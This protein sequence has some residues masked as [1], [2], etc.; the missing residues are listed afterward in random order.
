MTHSPLECAE[1]LEAKLETRGYKLSPF[2]KWAI[3][4]MSEFRHEFREYCA[5]EEIYT[6]KVDLALF[7]PME[8]I[9]HVRAWMKRIFLGIVALVSTL[10]AV[11]VWAM[12]LRSLL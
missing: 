4:Y 5:R 6:R 8:G 7:D 9:V 11:I 10:A 1:S 3:R 2:D 12:T